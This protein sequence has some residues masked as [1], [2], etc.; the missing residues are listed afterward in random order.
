MSDDGALPPPAVVD[1]PLLSEL[2]DEEKAAVLKV[3]AAGS[4]E[5]LRLFARLCR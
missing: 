4:S 3:P 2:S 5:D 1:Q